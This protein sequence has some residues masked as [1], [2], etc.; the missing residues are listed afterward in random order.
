[1]ADSKVNED[2][3]TIEPEGSEDRA[4]TTAQAQTEEEVAEID[5]LIAARQEVGELKEKYL[6]LYAE[7]E[8][9][10]KRTSKERLELISSANAGLLKALLPVA[11][12]F[13]RAIASLSA[14]TSEELAPVKEGID[15]VHAKFFR[16][17]E[18]E[19]LKPMEAKGEV[20]N[21]DFH[22]SVAQFPA[23][24][25]E[26]KGKIIE[27]LEKGYYLNDKVIRYAKVVVG[28]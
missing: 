6:R 8:N 11:D 16:T 1:M 23:P 13:E 17:L 25:E 2:D 14:I 12:D 4:D 3:L 15:L 26:R 7:F 18:G 24:E 10:R 20:F 28:V 27:V 19:G 21:P 22:E 9:F 5:P